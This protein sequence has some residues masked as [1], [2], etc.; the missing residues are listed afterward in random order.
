MKRNLTL[1]AL[2]TLATA[3]A[4]AQSSVSIYGRMNV[5][6]ERQKDGDVTDKVVQNNASRIGFRGLEEL[7]AGLRAGFLIEHGF[8]PDTGAQTQTAFWARKSNVFLEGPFGNL[9]LGN[10]GQTAAY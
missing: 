7:G 9:R 6:L 8:S 4:Y 1:A 5:T 10:M 3:S 2:A